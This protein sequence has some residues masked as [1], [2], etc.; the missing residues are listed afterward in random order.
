MPEDFAPVSV[1]FQLEDDCR[2]LIRLA[3]REDLGNAFDWT[4]VALVSVSRRGVCRLGTRVAAVCA[5]EVTVP[6]ILDEFEADIRWQPAV[7]D[8]DRL[9]AGET[10]GHLSG[11]V[12]DL[13][14]CERTILN[15]L[16]RLCGVATHT[17][18]H[19]ELLQGTACRLYDTR[20]TTPG[21]RRLEKYAVRCGGGHNHRTG[22]FD[23]FLI[24]D[25]H[26]GLARSDAPLSP[27]EAVA[28][29]RRWAGTAMEGRPA[30]SMIE[31]EVDSLDQ[32]VAALQARPQIVMLDNFKVD[33]LA[34]AVALRN[35]TAPEVELEASGGVRLETLAAIASSGVDR[36]SCGGL[37]HGATWVD[38]GLDWV[39]R[40]ELPEAELE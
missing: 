13:L 27:L 9:A 23:A 26:L 10:I 19:I 18:R 25:N 4:T 28:Q 5:G 11:N 33:D 32:L 24:K 6:W 22:L 30:P 34:K 17:A 3:I 35:Q 12:R 36:I 31:V 29:A 7:R 38:V 1:D 8:G 37:T 21:F 16:G 39:D 14:I 15:F 2:Q 20:K 40:R